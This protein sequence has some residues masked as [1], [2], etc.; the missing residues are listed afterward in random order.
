MFL[1]KKRQA[2]PNSPKR[3]EKYTQPVTEFPLPEDREQLERYA[4]DV[5]KPE[6][7]RLAAIKELSCPESRET[8]EHCALHDYESFNR[9]YA[10]RK[11]SY[12]ESREVIC[13]A[14]QHDMSYYVQ[15]EAVKMLPYPQEAELLKEI[16]NKEVSSFFRKQDSAVVKAAQGV[17]VH[18]GICPWCG[19]KA[20]VWETYTATRD[21]DPEFEYETE[22]YACSKCNW[23]E[24]E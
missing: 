1:F 3:T 2:H 4:L 22:G 15:E 9:A 16:A 5:T 23:Q 14:A 10:L 8:L 7:V 11:L 20:L 19:A 24:K 18:A 17:L 21:D 12:P 13:H 6:K